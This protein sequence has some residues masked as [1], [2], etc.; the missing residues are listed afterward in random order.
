MAWFIAIFERAIQTGAPHPGFLMIDSPQKNLTPRAESQV[1]DDFADP[2][3]VSRVWGR[4][5]SMT[6]DASKGSMQV[7]VV[8]N[9]PPSSANSHVVVRYGGR[10]GPAP[11]GLIENEVG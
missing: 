5:I 3:I 7:L 4:I 11:Y 1:Q 10:L 2:A 6:S 9:A 8:D